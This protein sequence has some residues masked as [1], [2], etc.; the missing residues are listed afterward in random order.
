MIYELVE[1]NAGTFGACIFQVVTDVKNNRVK[2]FLVKPEKSG[3]YSFLI[4]LPVTGM[5]L[6]IR[7]ISDETSRFEVYET[8]D[9][10]YLG[11]LSSAAG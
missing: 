11:M 1:H 7:L 4:R 3:S 9:S 6:S 10:S 8:C 5:G 2:P